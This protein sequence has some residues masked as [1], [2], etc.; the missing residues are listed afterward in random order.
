MK[1][2]LDTMIPKRG[3]LT[4][5]LIVIAGLVSTV[6]M[7]VV[8]RDIA[9]RNKINGENEAVLLDKVLDF[10]WTLHPANVLVKPKNYPMSDSDISEREDIINN[11]GFD[12]VH[13]PHISKGIEK[14]F[15]NSVNSYKKPITFE[16]DKQ[17]FRISGEI[18][19]IEACN[20]FAT[21]LRRTNWQNL[22]INGVGIELKNT[23]GIAINNSCNNTT[24]EIYQY[25]VE[26]CYET[27][28]QPCI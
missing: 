21:N 17:F 5:E 8:Q 14:F 25:T 7:Y 26:Y 22:K 18:N 20:S 11:L 2:L 15:P 1:R 10:V 28:T 6:T 19:A 3:N 27:V 24:D 9:S 13:Q 23:D 16:V 12:S 4:F